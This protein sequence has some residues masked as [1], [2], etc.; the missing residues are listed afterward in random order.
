MSKLLVASLVAAFAAAKDCNTVLNQDKCQDINYPCLHE[1]I[2]NNNCF[3]ATNFGGCGGGLIYCPATPN[4]NEKRC[5]IRGCPV[6]SC[7]H[8]ID[9]VGICYGKQGGQCPHGTHECLDDNI[10]P[11]PTTPAPTSRPTTTTTAAPTTATTGSP[12]SPAP[13]CNLKLHVRQSTKWHMIVK[14]LNAECACA[15]NI[16]KLQLN[17]NVLPGWTDATNKWMEYSPKKGMTFAYAPEVIYANDNTRNSFNGTD[18]FDIKLYNGA[19]SIQVSDVFSTYDNGIKELNM[20]F[21]A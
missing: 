9:S 10:V 3:A 20:N 14:V 7:V 4:V 18:A 13:A 15:D 5:G 11:P 17:S 6:G 8:V 19:D 16:Q 21:C 1:G 12:T 2:G